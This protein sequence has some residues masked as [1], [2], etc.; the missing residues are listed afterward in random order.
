MTGQKAPVRLQGKFAHSCNYD[1]V[2]HIETAHAEL[3]QQLRSVDNPLPLLPV[4]DNSKVLTFFWWDNFDVKKENS[5]GSLHTSHGI[6]YQ[7]EAPGCIETLL[8][9][10]IPRSNR[11]SVSV[12]P[13]S[14]PKWKIVPHKDPE[15]F[16]EP[17]PQAAEF[18]CMPAE[19]IVT[20]WKLSR[21]IS[22]SVSQEIS[23]FVGFVL[24]MLGK[25]SSKVTRKTFLPP[26]RNPITDYSSVLECI[27]Q[28]QRLAKVSNMRYTHITTDAGAAIKFYQVV[29]N[30]QE[31]FKD[32]IIYLGDFHAIMEF[33]GTIGKFI[34]GSGF[35]EVVYEAGLCTAGG[36]IGVLTGKHYNRSWLVHECFAEAIDR[37]FCEEFI[38]DVP[39]DL[40]STVQSNDET[41]ILDGVLERNDFKNYQQQY[42]DVKARCIQGQ[43]GKTPRYWMMYQDTVD[44]QHKL[45]LAINTN[46][47][48][49]RAQCWKD[50]LPLCFAMNKHNYSRYGAYYCHQLDNL[51]D[52]HPGAREELQEKGLSVCRNSL[53]IGQS[54]DGAG[55]QTFMSNS[56]TSG[57]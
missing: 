1:K 35:E 7:E 38:P 52:T 43:F 57:K 32:V 54:I 22:S 39:T 20:L 2:R 26:I 44:R 4:N 12:Q 49:L 23:R 3:A 17:D 19:N 50:S 36:I 33:F 53:N 28:S 30:Y 48:D 24:K 47:Y 18:D 41:L 56:K 15:P 34:T 29:W 14:L 42:Q 40:E 25:E 55:E 51:E 45:H 11:R 9:K 21:R 31:D 8:D 5:Q 13:A 27:Y 10:S 16:N 6:A 37:L 46:N